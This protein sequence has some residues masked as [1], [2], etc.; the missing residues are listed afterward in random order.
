MMQGRLSET[1][2][3]PKRILIVP[4]NH[5]RNLYYLENL[6]VLA[7]LVQE[8]G[9]EVRIGSLAATETLALTSA[10]GRAVTE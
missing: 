10:S 5:T 6:A 1:T 9:V 4:E 3:A 2:P 8:T 7:D